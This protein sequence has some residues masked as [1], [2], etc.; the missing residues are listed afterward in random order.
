MRRK[1]LA[2]HQ[3]EAGEWV[4]EM[5]CGHERHVRHEPQWTNRPWVL[6]EAGRA[7]FVGR[8]LTCALCAPPRGG[9]RETQ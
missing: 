4:A 9:G 7:T 1:V 2:F 8:E 6:S 5:E 3:D